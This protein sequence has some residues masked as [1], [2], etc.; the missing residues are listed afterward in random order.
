M[1]DAEL[2]TL[3][4]ALREEDKSLNE[5]LDVL[6]KEHKVRITF[7]ELRMLVAEIEKSEPVKKPRKKEKERDETLAD[8]PAADL[9]TQVTIDQIMQPGAQLSG[10]ANLQSGA[11]IKWS[12]DA[13]R[14]LNVSLEPG[15]SQPTEQDIRQ[16]QQAL[17]QKLQ[18]GG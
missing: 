8:E 1:E 12:V 10:S 15:S 16:F 9:G 18:R 2:R 5:I 4:E 7:L 11:K 3:V 14:R 17:G 6:H 13:M